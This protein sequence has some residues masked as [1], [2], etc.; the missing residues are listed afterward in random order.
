MENLFRERSRIEEAQIVLDIWGKKDFQKEKT[1][2]SEKAGWFTVRHL[3][4]VQRTDSLAT[5]FTQEVRRVIRKYLN[6]AP[7][8]KSRVGTDKDWYPIKSG[9]VFSPPFDDDRV[10]SWRRKMTSLIRFRQFCDEIGVPYEAAIEDGVNAIYFKKSYLMKFRTVPDPTTLNSSE[11]KDEVL[12]GWAKRIEE[13][14]QYVNDDAY[15]IAKGT[16]DA[17]D[18]EKLILDQIERKTRPEFSVRTFITKGFISHEA[19]K[20]RFPALSF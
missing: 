14:I 17:L 18:H 19:V 11:V 4:I 20:K 3:T 1:I 6:D 5:L 10:K 13:R 12:L 9:D 2:I 8:V 15:L 7:A 16:P